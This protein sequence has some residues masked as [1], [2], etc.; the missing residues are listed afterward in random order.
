MS[1]YETICDCYLCF[2]IKNFEEKKKLSVGRD[3]LY[4]EETNW[5]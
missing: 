2:P 3:K 5:R 1:V 4:Q